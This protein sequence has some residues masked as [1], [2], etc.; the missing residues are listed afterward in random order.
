MPHNRLEVGSN[1]AKCWAFFSSLSTPRGV[2]LVQVPL[3][4]TVFSKYA[5]LST[6]RRTQLHAEKLA[7]IDLEPKLLVKGW[8]LTKK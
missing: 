8:T 1:P 4:I 6:L 5:L 7:K 3:G 2:S